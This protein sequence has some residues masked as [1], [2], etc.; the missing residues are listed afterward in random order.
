MLT[1]YKCLSRINLFLLCNSALVV[2]M[3][4]CNANNSHCHSGLKNVIVAKYRASLSFSSQ[5]QAEAADHY[6][7]P[8][9]IDSLRI[10]QM[11]HADDDLYSLQP[12]QQVAATNEMQNML[13]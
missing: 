2:D 4:L 1:I 9:W 7:L 3:Q 11:Q 13:Q 10:V 6:K 5:Q 8:Q 12:A